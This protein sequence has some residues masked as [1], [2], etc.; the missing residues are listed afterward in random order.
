MRLANLFASF[1]VNPNFLM[2][3][4]SGLELFGVNYL[5]LSKSFGEF[6]AVLLPSLITLISKISFQGR[7]NIK[8]KMVKKT[9]IFNA[10]SWL[11][12]VALGTI[13][14]SLTKPSFFRQPKIFSFAIFTSSFLCKEVFH[15]LASVTSTTNNSVTD[16][17]R[18]RLLYYQS[19]EL[20]NL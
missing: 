15:N 18:I 12:L 6:V 20:I 17:C 4:S 11:Q 3:P 7:E 5:G 8:H 14:N 16:A 19:P 9:Y 13:M 1:T 2:K 10:D